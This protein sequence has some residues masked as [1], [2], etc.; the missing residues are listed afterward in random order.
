MFVHR[1]FSLIGASLLV[2]QTACISIEA[3]SFIWQ[4]RVP[5]QLG[6]SIFSLVALLA[7]LSSLLLIG[8]LFDRYIADIVPLAYMMLVSH[9][10]SS[11]K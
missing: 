10:S 6:I 5:L 11:D 8:S 1:P 4:K 3:W 7:Y 9:A 2:Y